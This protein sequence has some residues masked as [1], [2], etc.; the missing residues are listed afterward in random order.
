MCIEYFL[1]RA[2]SFKN[3]LWNMRRKIELGLDRAS[4]SLANN[5]V[6][7]NL[8]CL[9]CSVGVLLPVRA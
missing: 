3:I 5:N 2:M 4:S 1:A 7:R 9:Q 8:I 6:K